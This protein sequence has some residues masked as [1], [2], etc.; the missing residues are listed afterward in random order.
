MWKETKRQENLPQSIS[1]AWPMDDPIEQTG[2]SA[3]SPNE[4]DR[5]LQQA[6]LYAKSISISANY[7]VRSGI[8]PWPC[9]LV[10]KTH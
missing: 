2:F 3:I 10:R 5:S 8:I 7:I 9:D 6:K 4:I 1:A